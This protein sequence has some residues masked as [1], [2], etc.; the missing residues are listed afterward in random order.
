MQVKNNLFEEDSEVAL[1]KSKSKTTEYML[2]LNSYTFFRRK[3]EM[4][5]RP[6][7]Q[8]VSFLPVLLTFCISAARAE[9]APA[10][11]S[12]VAAACGVPP[13]GGASAEALPFSVCH[14]APLARAQGVGRMACASVHSARRTVRVTLPFSRRST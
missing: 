5:K 14:L 3:Q 4:L 9:T 2:P 11:S 6:G 1:W 13:R 12:C 8:N 10:V 7:N